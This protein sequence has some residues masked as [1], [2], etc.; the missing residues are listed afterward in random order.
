M[1]KRKP[2]TKDDL[3]K[4][5]RFFQPDFNDLLI[6]ISVNLK[7]DIFAYKETIRGSSGS[8]TIQSAIDCFNNDFWIEIPKTNNVTFEE[9]KL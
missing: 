1:N 6:C 2:Y 9:K 4:Y 5:M 7:E 3:H 8:V